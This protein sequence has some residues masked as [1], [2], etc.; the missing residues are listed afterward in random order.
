MKVLLGV[1]RAITVFRRLVA[2]LRRREAEELRAFKSVYLRVSP[3]VKYFYFNAVPPPTPWCSA[4]EEDAIRAGI[5]PGFSIEDWDPT[6]PPILLMQ[7]VFDANSLGR[8]IYDWTLFL[9]GNTS[10][11]A[12]V[13]ADLWLLLIK[14]AG[15]VKHAD[16]L[17]P[18]L[19]TRESRDL[20]EDF[21]EAGERLWMRLKRLI[22]ACERHAWE[23]FRQ[24]GLRLGH[25]TCCAFVD[26]L[27]RRDRELKDMEKMMN[28]LRIWIVRFD[29][30]CG[31]ILRRP[32]LH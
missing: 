15:K 10:P 8:W 28:A 24:D 23:S 22:K 14:L 9:C 27:F 31:E 5:P 4:T 18:S 13:A 1:L 32:D 12:D 25:R 2:R 3:P 29:V 7:N 20:L 16:E 19:R 17:V 30:S 11:A 26:A 6:E 21:L